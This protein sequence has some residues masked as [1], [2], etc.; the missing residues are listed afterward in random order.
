MSKNAFSAAAHGLAVQLLEA[1]DA[2]ELPP[3]AIEQFKKLAKHEQKT[4]AAT[5]QKNILSNF[6]ILAFSDITR[7][8]I[9]SEGDPEEIEQTAKDMETAAILCGVVVETLG[10]KAHPGLI[11]FDKAY[12][13]LPTGGIRPGLAA[14]DLLQELRNTSMP[15]AKPDPRP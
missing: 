6:Q 5:L 2:G 12:K 14:L 10:D 8:L 15:G 9:E 7:A 3:D 4:V 13:A 11:L 1:L